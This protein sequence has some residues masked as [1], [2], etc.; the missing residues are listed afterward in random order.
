M[1]QLDALRFGQG[2]YSLSADMSVRD[3]GIT[4]VIGPSGAGKSTLL[5]LIAGFLAPR[6]GRILWRG[7]DIT[8]AAPAD[9]PVTI[10]FQDN[11]LFPHLDVFRNVALGLSPSLRLSADER[12]RV[13]G[14]LDRVGLTGIGSRKPAALSGGQQSRVALA[15]VLVREKPVVLLDEPFSALGPALR[16]EMLDLVAEVARD[17]GATVLIVSH[18][19]GDARRVAEDAILVAKGVA[20]PPVA[21][22]ALFADP[23]PELAAYLGTR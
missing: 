7:A 3:G 22:E 14:A 12:A 11:N 2:D 5:S 21:T 18:E 8:G 17:I 13:D 20:R 9:R 6:A 15:R 1:L 10:V 23:P 19:P 16:D 4:A